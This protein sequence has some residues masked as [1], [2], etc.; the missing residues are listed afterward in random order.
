MLFFRQIS[1]FAFSQISSAFPYSPSQNPH[2]TFHYILTLA[3]LCGIVVLVL[4]LFREDD[5]ETH[6]ATHET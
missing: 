2:S 4:E 6:Y 1:F 3:F 5:H